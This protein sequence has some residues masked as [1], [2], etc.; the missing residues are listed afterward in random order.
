MNNWKILFSSRTPFEV[1]LARNYLESEGIETILQ[2]ELASQIY[3][4]A[5]DETKLLVKETDL[6]KGIKIL[7]RGGYIKTGLDGA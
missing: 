2:N 6:E 4:N 5:V 3:S 7:I 1:N